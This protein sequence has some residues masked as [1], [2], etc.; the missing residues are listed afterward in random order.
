MAKRKI[1]VIISK[2]PSN[3]SNLLALRQPNAIPFQAD[4]ACPVVSS[5]SSNST[6][7]LST[8]IALRAILKPMTISIGTTQSPVHPQ[9]TSKKPNK[10]SFP[11]EMRGI[12]LK[13][14]I[15]NGSSGLTSW[16]EKQK[17]PGMFICQHKLQRIPSTSFSWSATI[18]TRW[19]SSTTPSRHSKPLR[20][21][22]HKMIMRMLWEGV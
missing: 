10:V 14:A 11:F 5:S 19:A 6:M 2:L 4:S 17:M 8:W 9:E 18:A 21:L 12:K 20:R 13:N 7:S 15:S 16:M 1:R 3:S 22:I